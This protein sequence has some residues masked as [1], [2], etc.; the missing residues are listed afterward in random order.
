MKLISEKELR[1]LLIDSERLRRLESGGV[2]NWDWYYEALN[3]D[4]DLED[5]EETYLNEIVNKY[6]DYNTTFEDNYNFE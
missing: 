5:W 4:G 1:G 6:P 2:D 3:E